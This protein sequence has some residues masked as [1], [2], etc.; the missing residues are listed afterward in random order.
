MCYSNIKYFIFYY[1]YLITKK[2]KKKKKKKL[3]LMINNFIL[4]FKFFL[5]NDNKDAIEFLISSEIIPLFLRIIEVGTDA[6]K[7]VISF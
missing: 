1:L 6:E 2:K 7:N 4:F 3:K 5:K